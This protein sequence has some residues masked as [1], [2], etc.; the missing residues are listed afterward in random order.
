VRVNLH[1]W[2]T[3]I[4][5]S[6]AIEVAARRVTVVEVAAGGGTVTAYAGEGLPEGAVVPA[7]TGVN[8]A[9]PDL[10]RTAIKRA[11]ERAGLTATRRAALVVPDSV[12]RVSLLT[13]DQLPPRAQD[14]EQLVMWQ[15]RK[16]APFPV[17]EA[18]V[19]HFPAATDGGRHSVAAVM[20]RR[21]VLAQYEALA[22]GLG[23]HA[24]IVDLASFNVMNAILSATAPDGR[25]WLVVHVAAEAT[26]LAILRGSSLMFYRHRPSA[27]DEPLG[28]LVHQTAMY[29]EDRLGGGGFGRVWLSGAGVRGDEARRQI[30]SRLDSPLEV[31]DVRPVTT[32]EGLESPSPDVLDAL[33]APVGVLVR[34]RRQ[35][36]G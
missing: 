32:V 27:D 17:E 11:L 14:L 28:S 1:R 18:L 29:H 3:P 4:P 26:T 12:A 10:V 19:S 8:V 21:D 20:A 6:V 7:L 33:A 5:P 16:S 34:D 36:Q 13:F 31:V 22:T 9:E 23:I 2:L 30:S 35:A 24:G 25:D 15:L